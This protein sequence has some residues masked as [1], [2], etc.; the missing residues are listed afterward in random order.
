MK[1]IG[2]KWYA[3]IEFDNFPEIISCAVSKRKAKFYPRIYIPEIKDES[4]KGIQELADGLKRLIKHAAK[5]SDQK[6][7]GRGR[8]VDPD[9][10]M[11]EN[12]NWGFVL[13]PFVRD[14]NRGRIVATV[15]PENGMVLATIPEMVFDNDLPSARQFETVLYQCVQLMKA[16][17]KGA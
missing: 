10:G 6:E 3:T 2:G 17:G 11:D 1:L 5:S 8:Q 16:Y 13:A 9:E 12:G 15:D 14:P 7:P 4:W